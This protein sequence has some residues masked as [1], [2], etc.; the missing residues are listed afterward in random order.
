MRWGATKKKGEN[1]KPDIK[2][3]RN[4]VNREES[5]EKKRRKNE[6]EKI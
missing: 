4:R 5:V 2:E 3:K 1:R 6:Q